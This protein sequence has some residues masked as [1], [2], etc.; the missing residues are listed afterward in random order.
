[1]NVNEKQK[2]ISDKIFNE[3]EKKL[4][5]TRLYFYILDTFIFP[6]LLLF[7]LC[8]VV[9]H[10]LILLSGKQIE[11]FAS[12]YEGVPNFDNQAFNVEQYF[13]IWTSNNIAIIVLNNIA[14]FFGILLI[15]FI[16][17]QFIVSFVK[18]NKISKHKTIAFSLMIVFTTTS[19]I[20]FGV[21]VNT[22]DY[23]ISF[24]MKT[25]LFYY[26]PSR[27]KNSLV[28]FI[29]FSANQGY[30]S[31][32]DQTFNLNYAVGNYQSY[33]EI[34]M[35]IFCV[36]ATLFVFYFVTL[37]AWNMKNKKYYQLS[38]SFLDSLNKSLNDSIIEIVNVKEIKK[39]D[40]DTSLSYF[41]QQKDFFCENKN[42]Y[43]KLPNQISYTQEIDL[44][45]KEDKKL[46]SWETEDKDSIVPKASKKALVKLHN[47]R[48]LDELFLKDT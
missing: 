23:P 10:I 2:I 18:K 33:F 12:K 14:I 29:R 46:V 39:D 37:F 3:I 22:I 25:G 30:E 32:L 44:S 26:L 35:V 19:V 4:N 20:F 24:D 48:K 17:S 43:K 6:L 31:F 40:K 11:S 38:N 9:S 41:E 1:M 7:F 15:V 42:K 45:L 13:S 47:K 21:V 34:T 16:I 27:I 5:N 36:L 8:I 28:E